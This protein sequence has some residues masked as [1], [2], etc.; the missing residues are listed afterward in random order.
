MTAQSDLLRVHDCFE[1]MLGEAQELRGLQ[2]PDSKQLGDVAQ[3][4][5]LPGHAAWE[6]EL[7]KSAEERKTQGRKGEDR[8][9]HKRD[10]R[11]SDD[12]KK[13]PSKKA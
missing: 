7:P 10:V 4:G 13:N 9:N 6:Q 2:G 8:E 3:D 12:T 1:V 11:R 5:R